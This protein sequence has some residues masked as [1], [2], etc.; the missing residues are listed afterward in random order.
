MN[1]TWSLTQAKNGNLWMASYG[2]GL[3]VLTDRA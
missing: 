1:E 2:S 3:R